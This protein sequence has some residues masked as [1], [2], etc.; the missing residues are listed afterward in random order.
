[1]CSHELWNSALYKHELFNCELCSRELCSREMWNSV[2]D[3]DLPLGLFDPF[4]FCKN[5]LPEERVVV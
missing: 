3:L 5:L 4:G 2:N 1:M